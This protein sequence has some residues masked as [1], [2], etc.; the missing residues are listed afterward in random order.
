[1]LQQFFR[2]HRE[3]ITGF[4]GTDE[5]CQ[6]QAFV[7]GKFWDEKKLLSTNSEQTMKTFVGCDR[8]IASVRSEGVDFLLV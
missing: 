7:K 4:W 6:K 3:R 1:M 8:E 2:I 5:H